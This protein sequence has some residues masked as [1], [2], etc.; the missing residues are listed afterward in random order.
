MSPE[1]LLQASQ[2]GEQVEFLP[3]PAGIISA[4]AARDFGTEVYRI[5]REHGT[6]GPMEEGDKALNIVLQEASDPSSP[7]HKHLEWDDSIAGHKHRLDQ[8]R[9][10][11]RHVYIQVIHRD[12]PQMVRALVSVIQSNGNGR[13][14]KPILLVDTT[15][16]EYLVKSA[17]QELARWRKR[18]EVYSHLDEISRLV[19]GVEGLLGE[20]CDEA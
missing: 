15:E 8:C 14:Y 17:R 9:H 4:E 5:F 2:S 16:Q 6:T 18:Y 19:R 10:Y 20:G 1:A 11:I 13:S 12:K 7:L 3:D